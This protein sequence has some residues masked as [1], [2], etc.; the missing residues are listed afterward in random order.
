MK[1]KAFGGCIELGVR[2]K[3]WK[4]VRHSAM[5][6]EDSFIYLPAVKSED[7]KYP[8]MMMTVGLYQYAKDSLDES[9]KEHFLDI[10]SCSKAGAVKEPE[11]TPLLPPPPSLEGEKPGHPMSSMGFSASLRPIADSHP[12]E[13]P[14]GVGGILIRMPRVTSDILVTIQG[15]ANPS[16]LLTIAKSAVRELKILHWE[17][18]V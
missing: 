12:D 15:R 5:E 4:N 16:V 8:P 13:V 10:L 3:S 18:F 6:N 1:L 17:L 14:V 2:E 11:M 9:I 7:K